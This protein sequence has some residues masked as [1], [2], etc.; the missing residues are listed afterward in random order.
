M[1]K[2]KYCKI[3]YPAFRLQ[4]GN[5]EKETFE[6]YMTNFIGVFVLPIIRILLNV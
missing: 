6:K 3:K 1:R 4:Y 5:K 2:K